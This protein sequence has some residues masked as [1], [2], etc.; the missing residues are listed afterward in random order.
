VVWGWVGGS[1][2]L[3]EVDGDP[4]ASVRG[5][6]EMKSSRRS[7]YSDESSSTG[8]VDPFFRFAERQMGIRHHRQP[9]AQAMPP[10][11]LGVRREW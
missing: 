5:K 10:V 3:L 8:Q 7:E 4:S 11:A 9:V 1:D 6:N 2:I